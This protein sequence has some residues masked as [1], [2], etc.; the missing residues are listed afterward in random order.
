MKA[1]VMQPKGDRD[2]FPACPATDPQKSRVE[3]S[4]HVTVR[5]IT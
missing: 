1:K 4:S 5:L 3:G 2:V